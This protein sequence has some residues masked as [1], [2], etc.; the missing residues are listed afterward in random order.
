[1]GYGTMAKPPARILAS[2][3]LKVAAWTRT[4]K[5]DAE[6]EIFHGSD[7]MEAFLNRSDIVVCLLP[8][9][10][11]TRGIL[12][13]R[14][15]AMLPEGASVI[16]LGRGE[17]VVDEDLIAALDS[18]HISGASLDTTV[19]EP[20]PGDSPLWTHPKVTIMPHVARRPPLTQLA[21]QIIENIRRCK[22]GEAL[23]QEVDKSLGY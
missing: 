23:L 6:I 2:L 3:G 9:T 13:A 14:A 22:A 11:E 7:Q 1:M 21:P 12:D 20:L 17:H 19:P 18:G 5:P 4:P 15:F 10:D 16:N 8:A